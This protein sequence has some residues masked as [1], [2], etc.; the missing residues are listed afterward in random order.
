MV[1]HY[2]WLSLS[3]RIL[4]KRG[5][6]AAAGGEKRALGFYALIQTKN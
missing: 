1:F 2:E 3:V 4:D 5:T 6:G